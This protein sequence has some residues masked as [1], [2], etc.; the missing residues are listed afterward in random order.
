MPLRDDVVGLDQAAL[1]M[2]PRQQRLETGQAARADPDV[3]CGVRSNSRAAQA[4][5]RSFSRV[6]RGARAEAF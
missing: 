6:R 3:E 2:P 5:R 1:G 4:L